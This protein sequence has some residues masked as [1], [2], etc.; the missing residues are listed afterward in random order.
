MDIAFFAHADTCGMDMDSD[1]AAKFEKSCCDDETFTLQGQEDLKVS[2][3]D[4]DLEQQVFLVSYAYSYLNTL[5]EIEVTP[6]S[7][8]GHPPPLL[9]KDYQV[10]YETFLI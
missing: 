9:D 8:F 1:K 5:Q 6:V 2:F 10:L 7:N 4:L 3:F